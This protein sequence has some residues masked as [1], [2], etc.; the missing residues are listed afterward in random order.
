MAVQPIRE[1]AKIAAMKKVLRGQS[2]RDEL[3][4]TLGINIH[5]RISDLL[6]FKIGDVVDDHGRARDYYIERTEKKTGK[7]KTLIFN[8]RLRRL[9]E[10][11][12]KT[13]RKG[14]APEEYLF[15]SRKRNAQGEYVL[16]RVQAYRIIKEAA[17]A[18]GIKYRIGTHT[19]RK[20]FGYHALRDGIATLPILQQLYN[21]ASQQDTLIYIGITQDE[22][23]QVMLSVDL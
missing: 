2:L 6:A 10:N 1:K 23:D 3:L 16:T 8:P 12:I 15:K 9:I 7:T 22:M 4:F 5:L 20:T 11:Y 17:R 18:V 21:H 13:A 19:M 14:A